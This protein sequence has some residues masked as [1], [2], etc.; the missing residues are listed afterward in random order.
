MSQMFYNARGFS[1]DISRWD[2]RKVTNTVFMFTGAASY[3]GN[4]MYPIDQSDPVF[5]PG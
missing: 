1:G 5:E 4:M 2:T 3:H